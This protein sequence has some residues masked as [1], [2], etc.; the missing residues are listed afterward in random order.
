MYQRNYNSWTKH[1]EFLIL[2]LFCVNAAFMLAWLARF[3][4]HGSP[5]GNVSYR[6]L[7]IIL[8]LMYAV[9]ALVFG[10]YHRV[11]KRG[12]FAELT[13]SA[14]YMFLSLGMT[15][16]VMYAIKESDTY[17]RLFVLYM[18]VFFILTDYPARLILK[19]HLKSG[20]KLRSLSKKRNV[21]AVSDSSGIARLIESIE[22][23]P[24][25]NLN[26]AAFS[27]TDADS[28][29]CSAVTGKYTSIPI[30]AAS[31][32]ICRSWI[33][34]VFVYA[35]E[36][37]Q[38]VTELL[39]NCAEMG[40]TVHIILDVRHADPSKQFTDTLDDRTV[41]TAAYSYIAPHQAVIKR[42][43]DIVA[44]VIGSVIAAVIVILIGPVIFCID[45]GPVIFRQE[46]V[47]QN[48]KHFR[49]YKLRSMYLNADERKKDHLDYNRVSDGMMIIMDNDPRVLPVIGEFIRRTSLDEYP[50]FFNV[51]KGEMSVVGTRPPTV[52]EWEKYKYHH[53]ARLAMKP[54][55]TGMWQVSGRSDITDFEQVVELDTYY[56]THFKLSLDMRILLKTIPALLR[57]KGAE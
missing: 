21:F 52:D 37:A 27:V 30:S 36:T 33:D 6:T 45:P 40:V 4:A 32:Y 18:F 19:K 34:E 14:G 54:G 57:E 16:V 44:G 43:F 29:D 10:I 25:E 50:Q 55:I 1:I 5:Y 47:G 42:L 2:D 39:D 26:V 17:S 24:G 12:Y 53:R 11:L 22:S 8:S 38:A 51:L 20:K 49:I 28:G 48:G 3:G 31:D 23:D 7:I 13:N 46:R 35:P 41:Y 15:L 56:I 9:A